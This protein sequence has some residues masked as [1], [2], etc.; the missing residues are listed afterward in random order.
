MKKIV[1]IPTL[2]LAAG[3]V[4]LSSCGGDA[5]DRSEAAMPDTPQVQTV[6]EAQPEVASPDYSSRQ[7]EPAATTT[8]TAEEP[9]KN[10][11]EK[12]SG[13]IRE[14]AKEVQ[15]TAKDVQETKKEVEKAAEEI[16]NVFGG[17]K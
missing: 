11:V 10:P 1:L 2:F 6:P 15:K 13:D 17:K 9:K 16:E 7:V 3:L 8:R 5:D 12:T 14:G 4:G